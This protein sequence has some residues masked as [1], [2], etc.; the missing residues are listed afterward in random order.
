[1]FEGISKK[2]S[3][4]IWYRVQGDGIPV[5]FIMG[6]G[7]RGLAWER[8]VA[9]LKGDHEC[10]YFD[11]AGLGAS[12]GI[13]RHRLTMED[14]ANDALGVMD[15]LGWESAHIV[16]I[17]M[18][19]MIAQHVA[20][21]AYSR[22]RTLTLAATTAG[23]FLDVLPPA[24]GLKLFLQ[25]SSVSGMEAA[26]VLSRLLFSQEFLE[27]EPGL[28]RELLQGDFGGAPPRATQMAHMHAVTNHNIARRLGVLRNTP[29][30]I[31]K[32]TK[33]VL[34]AP[35][36]CDRLHR[37]IPR[38]TLH[39]ISAGHGVAREA[40]DE[41]NALIRAHMAAGEARRVA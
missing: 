34:V 2:T 19:G 9:S 35:Q 4:D 12:G 26:S 13:S 33:D 30:M 22:V 17:S 38:S 41:F 32:P 25:S 7:M 20:V 10:A 40:A 31:I 6:F 18:G 29:T 27:R 24:R 21:K 36:Q 16:G 39:E 11:H 28:A 23:G 14:M 8:Q 5:L 1:M 3:H 37:L 15:T